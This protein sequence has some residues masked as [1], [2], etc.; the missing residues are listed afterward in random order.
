MVYY[1]EISVIMILR[2]KNMKMPVIGL[3]VWLVLLMGTA[4]AD[5]AREGNQ[6]YENG[7]YQKAEQLYRKAIDR[8]P[9]NAQLYFNLANTLAKQGKTQNAIDMYNRFKSMSDNPEDKAKAEYNIANLHSEQQNYGKAMKHYRQSLRNDPDDKEAK[10]NY[11]LAYKKQ[12]QNQSQKKQNQD[13]GN[14]DQNNKQK[15]NQDQQGDQNQDKQNQQSK[16]Q[17]NQQSDKEGNKN[18]QNSSD[19][20]QNQG[21]KQDQ[22]KQ[23]AQPQPN[24]VSKA[25]A[26]QILNALENR[27][28]QLLQELRDKKSKSQSSNG[29]DW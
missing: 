26:E 2:T 5:D 8:E 18:Q 4:I 10:H 29:K 28:K 3:A 12:K 25:E 19:Q 16:N 13:Q 14:K 15:Q 23:K 11:E 21:D 9:K 17:Q 24:R 6:A 27:E 1:P 22:Q 20:P 7:N